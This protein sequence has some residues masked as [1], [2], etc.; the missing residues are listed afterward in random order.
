M[1]Q[2]IQFNKNINNYKT[3]TESVGF[4]MFIIHALILFCI[5]EIIQKPFKIL[6]GIAYIVL[7]LIFLITKKIGF[8][9]LVL[10]LILILLSCFIIYHGAFQSSLV[11]VVMAGFG[12][13]IISKLKFNLTSN[14]VLILNIVF[15]MGFLSIIL[16][17]LIY[18]SSD[19]RPKLGYE[20]NLSAAILFLFFL[21]SDIIRNRYGKTLVII[22]AMIILSR[23]LILALLLFIIIKHIIKKI[24]SNRKY[25]FFIFTIITYVFFFIFNLWFIENV[26]IGGVY[27]SSAERI[28]EVN[29]GSNKIRFTTNLGMLYSIFVEKD[30]FLIFG[31][32]N[33]DNV[34]NKFQ[35]IYPIMP[36]NELLTSIAE[37][38]YLSTIFFFYLSLRLY[39][40][41][42]HVNLFHYI[43]PLFLYTLI[44]WVRFIV[45]PSFEMIF[46]LMLL[47]LKSSEKT[48][49]K[50]N[51]LQIWK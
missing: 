10:A 36:H 51:S 40:N 1:R 26:E 18:R 3:T 30:P 44:L 37:Y 4:V 43:I 22:L 5:P 20:I 16:Q 42:F 49:F 11:N 39:R 29:D 17:M 15:W 21:F 38:G 47:Y 46:I 14:R 24:K 23:L 2:I 32:G 6:I 45:I 12:L 35:E 27:N 50:N 7:F 34:N 9:E 13:L 25:N 41:Y 48:S 31:Y 8:K 28:V 19:G 33:I